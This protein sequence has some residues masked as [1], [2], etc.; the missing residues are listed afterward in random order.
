MF[1]FAVS[2]VLPQVP[3]MGAYLGRSILDEV[4]HITDHQ[5]QLK[6]PLRREAS[7]RLDS[8]NATSCNREP[9]ALRN[10]PLVGQ[11]HKR[12]LPLHV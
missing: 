10:S 1:G 3:R 5:D 4:V 7:E 8:L 12:L 11:G 9:G 2:V 6:I